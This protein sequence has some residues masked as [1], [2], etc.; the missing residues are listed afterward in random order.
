MRTVFCL[1]LVFSV[2]TITHAQQ[3]ASID[4]RVSGVLAQMESKDL[5]AREKAFA[6]M[7]GLMS[8]E[9]HQ[10]HGFVKADVLGSFFERHPDQ[11]DRV[12]MGLIQLLSSENDT[13]I[14]G[15][16]T[17]PGTLTEEDG[18]YYA[19]V[20]DTVSSLDDERAIPALVGAMTTGGM[21]KRGLLKYGDKV[22]E[23]MLEQLQNP[24]GLVRAAALGMSVSLLEKRNDPSSHKRAVDIIRSALTDS[25]SVVRGHAIREIDC[26]AER[27]EF[28]PTLEKIAKTDPQKL[29]GKALDGGDGEEFYPVRSDARSVL[30]DIQSNKTC[31]P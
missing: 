26:L 25:S 21:A 2:S 29:A 11:A 18:E 4:S 28:V 1:F 20:I 7:M 8:E 9:Q 27:Q 3:S 17:V 23:P 15:K 16:T 5:S 30:R 24:D 10:G 22:L 31:K 6:D 13:F 19:E 14:P 12:K